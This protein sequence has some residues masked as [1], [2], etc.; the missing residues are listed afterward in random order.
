[1][2][3]LQWS[4]AHYSPGCI[5]LVLSGSQPARV[6]DAVIEEI[7]GRERGGLVDLP[8]ASS[9]P[10]LRPGDRVRVRTGPLTG[11]LGIH[12]GM[13][14][15][16]RVGVLLQLLGGQREVELARRSSQWSRR[17]IAVAARTKPRRCAS[18]RG[19]IGFQWDRH[20]HRGLPPRPTN[21]RL[22]TRAA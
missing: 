5:G 1:V 20:G 19:D 9:S 10:A 22:K 12:V 21:T 8:K 18:K 2:I 17:A 13:K 16:E 6:P 4:H 3:E 15:H 14:P 11:F 7:R